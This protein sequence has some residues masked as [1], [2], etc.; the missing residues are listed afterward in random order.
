MLGELVGNLSLGVLDDDWGVCLFLAIHVG[1][2]LHIVT[3]SHF[4]RL[5][6]DLLGSLLA[7]FTDSI[8]H[9]H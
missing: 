3:T 2:L 6:Y 4:Y 7:L 1:L 5:L 9:I 8:F